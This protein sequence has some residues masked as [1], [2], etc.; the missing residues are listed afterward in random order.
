MRVPVKFRSVVA[1]VDFVIGFVLLFGGNNLRVHRGRELLGEDEIIGA[2]S[3]LLGLAL[4]LSAS[5]ISRGLRP[6]FRPFVYLLMAAAL[7]AGALQDTLRNQP[8]SRQ[9]ILTWV[10]LM[11]VVIVCILLQRY[12]RSDPNLPRAAHR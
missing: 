12:V 1:G 11:I 2:L 9:D 5:W 6:R 4:F 3:M 10:L 8:M 7:S